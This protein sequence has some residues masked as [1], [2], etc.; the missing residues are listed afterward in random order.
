MRDDGPV[1]WERI[2]ADAATYLDR[3]LKP[4]G[5]A[6]LDAVV[7]S[8]DLPPDSDVVDVGCGEGRDSARLALHFGFDVLGVD[9]DG[10]RLERAR[11]ERDALEPHVATRL[12]F[13]RGSAD[14]IPRASAGADLAWCVDGL[15]DAPDLAGALAEVARVLRPGGWAVLHQCV[16]TPLLDTREAATVPAHHDGPAVERAITAA[17]LTIEED[18]DLSSEW[19]E[20]AEEASGDSLLR[21][22]RLQRQPD[23]F[24]ERFGEATYDALLLTCRLQV[25]RLLGKLADRVWLLR[26]P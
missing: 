9:P 4:R 19:A 26:R 21:L 20:A 2:D 11:R 13:S 10:L 23:R 12:S 5:R 1:T 7:R 14:A 17:G 16:A 3:S 15:R 25:F 18:Y 6:F 22:A 8:L 24:R